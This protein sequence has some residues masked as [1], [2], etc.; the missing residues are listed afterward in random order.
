MVA[1]SR[2]SRFCDVCVSVVVL[3]NKNNEVGRHRDRLE[4]KQITSVQKL[5]F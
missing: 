4:E 2:T 3:K 1:R 5:F